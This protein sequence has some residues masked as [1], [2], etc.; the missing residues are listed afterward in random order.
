MRTLYRSALTCAALAAILSPVA[1]A[2]EPDSDRDRKARVAL[3][4]AGKPAVVTAPAPRPAPK[5]YATGYKVAAEQSKPLVVYVGCKESPA[6]PGAVVARTESLADVTGPAAV[7]SYPVDGT[8]FV[9]TVMAC[10][11][12]GDALKTAIDR[13]A[14]KIDR[15]AAAKPAGDKPAPKPV[16][17]DIR[18]PQADDLKAEVADLKARLTAAEAKL[19]DQL[20]KKGCTCTGDCCKAAASAPAAPSV[21]APVTSS[22]PSVLVIA[23]RTHQLGA[24]GVYWPVGS[25]PS[26]SPAAWSSYPTAPTCSGGS[27]AVPSQY[28]IPGVS[29]CPGGQ[30][31][32]RR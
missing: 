1:R 19:Y 32:P 7:V 5:D 25:A 11:V 21:P 10:P 14:K 23:G 13:A 9:H 16:E 17:W 12:E 27:C 8:L 29:S 31:P 18:A 4:L 26:S 22:A 28:V 3:A 15:P 24:D 20:N 2:A 6:A 30:C